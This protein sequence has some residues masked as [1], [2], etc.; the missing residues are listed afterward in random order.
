MPRWERLQIGG[1]KIDPPEVQIVAAKLEAYLIEA[2][3]AEFDVDHST[4][5]LAIVA[6]FLRLRIWATDT[7]VSKSS[8]RIAP[9][10]LW[11]SATYS[12]SHEQQIFLRDLD[13]SLLNKLPRRENVHETDSAQQ[14]RT[15]AVADHVH[16]LGSILRGIDVNTERTLRKKAN[17]ACYG[18]VWTDEDTNILRISQ[19]LELLGRWRDYTSVVT[20]GWP[21]QA[22]KAPLLIPLTMSAQV[23][24]G[25]TMQWCRGRFINY[26]VFGTDVKM[27]RID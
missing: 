7:H 24:N 10:C 16:S 5:N 25:K 14:F 17:V 19:H 12:L 4:G 13:S 3:G 18:E 22:G 15:Y 23:E 21:N 8:R 9:N 2:T 26:K 1:R 6:S 20:Y 27:T 11:L